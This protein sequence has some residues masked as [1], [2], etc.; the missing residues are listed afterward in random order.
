ML[1]KEADSKMAQEGTNAKLAHEHWTGPW[2]VTAIEQPR[3]SYQVTMSGR[4]IRRR[5]VSAGRFENWLY[6]KNEKKVD[7][8]VQG[9]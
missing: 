8:W 4:R 1:V 7:G 9:L 3:I 2:L 5:T 6:E